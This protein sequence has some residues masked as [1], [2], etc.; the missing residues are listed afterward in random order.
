ME[1]FFL[2]GSQYTRGFWS[3]QVTGDQAVVWTAELQLNT[4]LDVTL[5]HRPIN[6][7]AQF[8]AFYDYGYGIF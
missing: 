8:Y 2:G 3:G 6:L 7:A 5:F 4:G 1:K